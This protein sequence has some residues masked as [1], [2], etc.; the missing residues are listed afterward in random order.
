[1]QTQLTPEILATP[2]GR[3]A[4]TILRACVHCGFCTATCPTYQ[5]TGDE[6][7]GPRGRIYLIK[8]M[9]EGEVTTERTQYHLDRCLTCRACETTC[10]SG[11][12]Y[13][14]LVEIGREVVEQKVSRPREQRLLRQLLRSIVPYPR[15]FATLLRV[16]SWFKPLLPPSLANKIYAVQ[17]TKPHQ[18]RHHARRVLA[19]SGCVQPVVAP[20]TNSAAARLLDRLGIT[21]LEVPQSGCCGAMSY[22][23][24]DHSDGLNFVRH[25]IDCWWPHIETGVEAL[26]ITASGCGAFVKEYGELLQHDPRYATKAARVAVLAKDLCELITPSDLQPYHRPNRPAIAFQNP[27]SL[28]HGQKISGRVEAL[29]S[30]VGYPLTAVPESHLCCGSAGSYSLLQPTMSQALLARKLTALNSGSPTLIVS[31]NIGCQ[32]HLASQSSVPV[33]HWIELLAE[34]LDPIER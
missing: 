8:Q 26:L 13:G 25:N 15:R 2:Q 31:A 20:A 24:G 21:L 23:T 29:L 3:E 33:K 7:D 27:C 22:H 16:G 12:R 4:E 9:L 18:P 5:L 6:L 30:A 34:S 1:M 28:Q 11:V 19:L 32:L 14:R 17:K 10:P